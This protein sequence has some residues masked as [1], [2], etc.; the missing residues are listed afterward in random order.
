MASLSHLDDAARA[1]AQQGVRALAVVERKG[2]RADFAF[3]AD[4]RWLADT[5]VIEQVVRVRG[6]WRVALVFAH[7]HNPLRLIRRH[8]MAYASPQRAALQG[9]YMRRLAARDQRGTLMVK[10]E[11][12]ALCAN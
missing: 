3:I 5:A 6:E 4:D 10:I 9:Y 12:L 11:Q 2:S 1:H 8:I 7:V